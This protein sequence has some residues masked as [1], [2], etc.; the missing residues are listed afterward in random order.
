[1]MLSCMLYTG[2][3][4]KRE[5]KVAKEVLKLCKRFATPTEEEVIA[6]AKE[7]ERR[8]RVQKFGELRKKAELAQ[9]KADEKR[10]QVLQKRDKKEKLAYV[11]K[12][13]N[14]FLGR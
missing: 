14:K 2:E 1:M 3:E 11:E 8:K 12:I 6:Y 7:K 13:K 5:I 4:D 10:K 9:R